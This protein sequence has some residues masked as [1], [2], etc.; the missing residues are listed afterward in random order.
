MSFLAPTTTLPD[1][2]LDVYSRLE[3][4]IATKELAPRPNSRAADDIYRHA[5]PEDLNVNEFDY[6][7]NLAADKYPLSCSES[8]SGIFSAAQYHK[9]F[10]NSRNFASRT[11]I[12]CF[13]ADNQSHEEW[14]TVTEEKLRDIIIQHSGAY[15]SREALLAFFIPLMPQIDSS[16]GNSVLISQSSVQE[17]YEAFQIDPSFLLNMLGRPDYWAPVTKIA[18]NQKDKLET[19]EY[20]C[21]HPRWNLQ[22]QGSPLSVYMKYDQARKLTVYIIAHKQQDSSIEALRNLLTIRAGGRASEKRHKMFLEDPFHLHLMLSMLSLEAAKF[23]IH[24]FRRFMWHQMNAVDDHLTGL[25]KNDR[26][27]LGVL[28]KELQVISQNADSLIASADVA[29]ISAKGIKNAHRRLHLAL[30]NSKAVSG[31]TADGVMYI[32]G[33]LQKQKMWLLNY[34]SRKDSMMNLVFNLVTQQDAANNINIAVDMRRDSA[35][36]SAIA[37]LTMIFLP[38]TFTAVGLFFFLF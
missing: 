7:Y 28:T 37:T 14:F 8:L 21:Q 1:T 3:S 15:S 2:P 13:W 32:L 12:S 33:S 24:R 18:L 36:M 10:A 35:S 22:V 38:A 6:D 11:S 25:I 23:H 4:T 34:R 26:E 5:L 17:L 31:G 27:E 19:C 30:S 20:S 29:I 9:H 16:F